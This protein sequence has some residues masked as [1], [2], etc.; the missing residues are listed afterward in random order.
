MPYTQERLR[1]ERSEEDL[2]R[3]RLNSIFPDQF[4]CINSGA[5]QMRGY[6]FLRNDNKKTRCPA[7]RGI[8]LY[9][10]LY[11]AKIS[12]PCEGEIDGLTTHASDT[13][14]VF[15]QMGATRRRKAGQNPFR[16]PVLGCAVT[17]PPAPPSQEGKLEPQMHV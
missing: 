11:G 15:P 2:S 10:N 5:T 17:T 3:I 16:S 13:A 7:V 8:G 6:V 1:I 4:V 12:P 14:N 9:A